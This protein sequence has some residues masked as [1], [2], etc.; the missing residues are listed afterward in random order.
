[1][2][3]RY[4]IPFFDPKVQTW[5]IEARLLRWLTFLWLFIGL[6]VLFSAS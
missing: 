5:A 2:D 3:L 6:V 1:M 4:L